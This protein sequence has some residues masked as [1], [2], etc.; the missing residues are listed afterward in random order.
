MLNAASH[1]ES[2]EIAAVEWNRVVLCVRL[3][4]NQLVQDGRIKPNPHPLPSTDLET[5]KTR[6]GAQLDRIETLSWIH[7]LEVRVDSLREKLKEPGAKMSMDELELKV[8]TRLK[9]VLDR[10]GRLQ[11]SCGTHSATT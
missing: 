7:H 8:I 3:K 9:E 6:I 11:T 1:L 2:S 4:Y 10:V 5:S